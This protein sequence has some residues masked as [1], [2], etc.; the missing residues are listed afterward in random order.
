LNWIICKLTNISFFSFKY[1]ISLSITIKKT[2]EQLYNKINDFLNFFRN[3][4]H[5]LKAL[6]LVLV[7]LFIRW[8]N[9]C[10]LCV[11][12]IVAMWSFVQPA[13]IKFAG[14]DLAA[15]CDMLINENPL[16]DIVGAYW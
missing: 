1:I 2:F 13:L 5:G 16:E 6:L 7:L 12:W 10:V 11:A 4:G 9:S 14:L 8:V 15:V 3:F